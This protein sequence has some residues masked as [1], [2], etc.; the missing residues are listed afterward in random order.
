MFVKYVH[1]IHDLENNVLVLIY[2]LK[3]LTLH[4]FKWVKLKKNIDSYF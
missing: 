2:D 1:M 3:S 4:V